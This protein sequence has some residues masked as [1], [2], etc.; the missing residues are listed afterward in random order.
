VEKVLTNYY[1]EVDSEACSGCET[2]VDRCQME[3]I[4]IGA[5]DE[6]EIDR[7]RC[8]GCGLC[9]P[10]CPEEA[11]TLRPKPESERRV[12]PATGREYVMQLAQSRGK[13]LIPLAVSK[14]SPRSS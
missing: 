3:A 12:P 7:D 5:N 8:I 4:R 6:A 14:Q 11:L 9:I 2:C 1:T 10:T 13:S